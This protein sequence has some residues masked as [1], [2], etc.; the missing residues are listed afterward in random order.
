MVFSRHL[1]ILILTELG[2]KRR[3]PSRAR[4]QARIAEVQA[5]R[6]KGLIHP[7]Y[8]YPSHFLIAD[9]QNTKDGGQVSIAQAKCQSDT[10]SI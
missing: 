8:T 6:I 7:I 10:L 5:P 9:H 3:T 4:H 1:G 2:T